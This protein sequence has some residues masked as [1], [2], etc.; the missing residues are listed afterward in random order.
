MAIIKLGATV[1]GIR[2]TIA[3]ITYSANKSSLYAKGWSQPPRPLRAQTSQQ[4]AWLSV[5]PQRWRD[6]TQAQRDDWDTYAADAAQELTNSLGEPYYASGFNWFCAINLWVLRLGHTY[7]NTAPT[8]PAPAAPTATVI[9]EATGAASESRLTYASGYFSSTDPS[10]F[11]RLVDSAGRQAWPTPYPFVVG[12]QTPG[13]TQLDF[14][15]ELEAVY[16]VISSSMR[17]FCAI[18]QQ[19]ST[20]GRRGPAT[21]SVVDVS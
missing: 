11:I 19:L 16:G 7:R 9:L 15:A 2:G 4:Q 8:N 21:L 18:H 10:I 5:L 1:T 13:G 6:R 17:G 3:G 20:Q 12:A 14:Q